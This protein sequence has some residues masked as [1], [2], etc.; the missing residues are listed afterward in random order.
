M[1]RTE[2][3]VAVS[4]PSTPQ[5]PKSRRS[6]GR[7][8]RT[9]ELSAAEVPEEKAPD[10]S[11][12]APKEPE[13]VIETRPA[14]EAETIASRDS[15][16]QPA[17]PEPMATQEKPAEAEAPRKSG[18]GG[19]V[20]VTGI[21]AGLIGGLAGAALMM[22]FQPQP[23]TPPEGF[24]ARLAAMESKL[25]NAAKD[26]TATLTPRIAAVETAAREAGT[27]LSALE[28][29]QK[30][31]D[32]NTRAFLARIDA[33]AAQE[34]SVSGAQGMV[35]SELNQQVATLDQRLSQTT[36]TVQSA[37][38]AAKQRIAEGQQQTAA[39]TA[40][41]GTLEQRLADSARQTINPLPAIRFALI[42]RLEQTVASGKPLA[43]ILNALSKTGI[44][45]PDLAAFIPFATTGV[46]NAMQLKNQFLPLAQAMIGQD[47]GSSGESV[48]DRLWRMSERVVRIRPRDNA[49]ATDIISITARIETAL[50]RGSFV[51]AANQWNSLPE[52][53]RQMSAE[54]GKRINDRANAAKALQSLGDKAVTTLEA[55]TK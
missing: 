12:E 45:A 18:S 47:R 38:D 13:D 49:G 26:P 46:P 33:I 22:A 32:T 6:K 54:W 42:T 29:H 10:V 51:D 8:P 15:S 50:D 11:P 27:R 37:L 16:E 40:R 55:S 2:V 28:G 39:I 5:N 53:A 31:L 19:K 36:G 3:G 52:S 44:T 9:I 34:T 7:E 25:Q 43:S 23:K 24:D 41:L 1:Y 17:E 35:S 20:A 30:D 21:A 14:E 4:D 48:T